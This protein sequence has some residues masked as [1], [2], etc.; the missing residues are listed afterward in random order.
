MS[1]FLTNLQAHPFLSEK[2]LVIL[3]NF[4][5]EAKDDDKERLVENLKVPEFCILI[6]HEN[7]QADK[8]TKLYKKLVQIAEVE[9]FNQLDPVQI[10]KWIQKKINIS[11]ALSQFL[12]EYCGTEMWKLDSEIK[13]LQSYAQDS[14][15]DKNCIEKLCSPSITASIFNLTDNIA[16]KQSKNSLNIFHQLKESGEDPIRSFFMIVR[17]FRILIQVKSLLDQNYP[18][19]EITKRLKLHPFVIKKS[20]QQCRN[21]SSL[22]LKQIHQKLLEIDHHFKTGINNK[23]YLL[24]IEKFI[25]NCCR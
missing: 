22:Q 8:R 4:L 13:K 25:I 15:I 10:S 16:Q 3:H 20:I 5:K 18:E 7:K 19:K 12:I 24:A 1:E 23:E 14:P 17:H 11:P 2:K 6:L 9:S 21:F